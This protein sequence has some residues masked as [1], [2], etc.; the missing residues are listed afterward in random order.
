MYSLGAYGDM[1]ADRERT[2]AYERALRQTLKPGMVVMEIGTGPG[3][4]A[5]LACKLGAN[6]VYA[7]ES[8]PVIQVARE[9]AAANH[10]ADKITFFEDLSTKIAIPAKAD[11]VISDMHGILPLLE[12]HIPSIAD[13]RRR[14]LAPG[15]TLIGREDRIWVAVVEAPKHYAK[16]VEPWEH[17]MFGQDLNPARRMSLNAM[18]RMHPVREQLLTNPQLWLTLD[19][20]SVEDP[21]AEGM[22]SW[23]AKRDGTGH[24]IVVW[25]DADLADGVSFSN[26]PGSPEMIYGSMFLPWLDPVPL[27]AG[28]T[29]CVDLQAKL[30]EK[31]YFW[32]WATRIELPGR[33][34]E[35]ATQFDQSQL[36]GAMLS[37]EKLRKSTST[38]I[39][40]LS[41]EGLLR[42]RTLDLM[43]GRASL[44]EIARRL[45]IEFP[46]RFTRWQQALSFAGAISTDN[47]R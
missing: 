18:H 37:P 44:E 11:L 36:K 12:H 19:Y 31:D 7:V 45:T 3:A 30:L 17:N 14:F 10:C 27:K 47:S 28:Q 23:K 9:I 38:Y 20:V 1:L 39:S 6:R 26:A 8:S 22:L 16:I 13:A 43:D 40:Q 42:R 4:M 32:R 25:F 35:I 24:G 5:V 2:G 41:E 46:G 34:G 33:P 21:D 15:G 29:V